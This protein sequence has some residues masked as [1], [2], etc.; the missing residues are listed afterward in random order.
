MQS[1]LNIDDALIA[2]FLGSRYLGRR[3][4]R[5]VEL[6]AL[7]LVDNRAT[8]KLWM[9]AGAFPRGIKIAGPSGRTL[10]WSVPEIVQVLA[11]RVAERDASPENDQ[12]APATERPCNSN[13]P[14]AAGRNNE[15][16]PW[17]YP[18]PTA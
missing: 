9:D 10:V 5:Y 8:L 15:E 6:E 11:E 14:L 13:D 7:G 1:Q 3:Y 12:G 17:I 18:P 4:L 16:L 2:Q